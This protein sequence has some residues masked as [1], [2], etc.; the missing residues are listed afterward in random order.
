MCSGASRDLGFHPAY[1]VGCGSVWFALAA[2]I[3]RFTSDAVCPRTRR[4][5]ETTNRETTN[6]E[7]TK[8]IGLATSLRDLQAREGIE[9]AFQSTV[10]QRNSETANDQEKA[11]PQKG[12]LTNTV[13]GKEVSKSVS[14]DMIPI[15]AS[16]A[17]DFQSR[18]SM[19]SY[20]TLI[21]GIWIT[22]VGLLLFLLA[23]DTYRRRRLAQSA[24]EVQKASWY[25]LLNTLAPRLNINR[26]I[27]LLESS[28]TAVPITWGR[29]RNA[30]TCWRNAETCCWLFPTG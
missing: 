16:M 11:V 8:P 14:I 24:R 27:H 6:R 9:V 18:V 25:V 2:I 13:V 15:D 20:S 29:M 17:S 5:D 19:L 30:E 7:T 22:G 26:P 28:K 21:G 1:G 3:G 12:V 10:Q 4:V 23:L